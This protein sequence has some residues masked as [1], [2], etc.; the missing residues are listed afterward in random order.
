MNLRCLEIQTNYSS[1]EEKE[2]IAIVTIVTI[3]AS[4]TSF[5]ILIVHQIILIVLITIATTIAITLVR[6]FFFCFQRCY[7]YAIVIVASFCK[8]ENL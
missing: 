2:I 3:I 5:A 7:N 6:I 1:A 4:M 8:Y